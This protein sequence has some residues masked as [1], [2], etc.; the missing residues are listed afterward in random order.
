MKAKGQVKGWVILIFFFL[1]SRPTRREDYWRGAFS[2]V[3][4]SAK[5]ST[6]TLPFTLHLKTPTPGWGE[7]LTVLSLYSG[8]C[9]W[10]MWYEGGIS[11]LFALFCQLPSASLVP[12][13]PEIRTK[14]S[15]TIYYMFFVF[16]IAFLCYLFPNFGVQIANCVFKMIYKNEV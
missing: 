10:C 2:L 16:Y 12:P 11:D 1:K 13:Q 14:F 15:K 9:A 6:L 8:R 5:K 4:N 7:G 3:K